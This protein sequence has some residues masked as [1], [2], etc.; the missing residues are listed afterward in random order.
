MCIYLFIDVYFTF[1]S[2]QGRSVTCAPRDFSE[3]NF[4]RMEEKKMLWASTSFMSA[5]SHITR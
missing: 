2:I 1:L 5:P 3:V 4:I